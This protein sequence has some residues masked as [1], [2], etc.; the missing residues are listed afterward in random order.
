MT[1]TVP[2]RHDVAGSG[3]LLVAIHGITENRRFWDPVPLA[4]RFRT[5]R[6]DLRGHGES[7][8]VGPYDPLTL[9]AD[10]HELLRTLGTEER[11][12]V[13]GHSFGGVIAT[14]YASRYPVRGVVDVDQTLDATP[15]PEQVAQAVRGP[16][17]EAFMGS[18]LAGMYGPLDPALAAELDA[19]RTLRQDVV[20]AAWEPLLDYSAADLG[21][22][23][24]DLTTLPAATPF[25]SLHGLPV[26]EGYA[27]WLRERIPGALV[28]NAPTTGTHYPHLADPAW[29]VER[30]TTF[31]AGGN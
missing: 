14:A 13:V 26:R 7:P 31:G 25:L 11:P 2:L 9:A 16:G 15:L 19:S 3:P 5:V 10:V 18:T 30:L 6:V 23:V 29:F 17:F 4:D 21:E 8:R 24:R 27:D 22:F 28:E 20:S 1:Q 12:L